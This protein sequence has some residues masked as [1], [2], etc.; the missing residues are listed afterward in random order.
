MCKDGHRISDDSCILAA[1]LP[2]QG[3]VYGDDMRVAPVSHAALG[4]PPKK[5]LQSLAYS[6]AAFGN[7]CCV[8]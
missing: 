3:G 4:G 8:E 5:E 2:I 1:R 7:P 6:W